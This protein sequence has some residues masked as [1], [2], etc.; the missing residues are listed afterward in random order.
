MNT[1]I[2]NLYRT[3]YTAVVGSVQTDSNLEAP[4]ETYCQTLLVA[5]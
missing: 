3:G 4:M 5:A 2:P 1:R